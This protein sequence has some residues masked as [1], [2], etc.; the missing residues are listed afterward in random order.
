MGLWNSYRLRLERKK[1]RVRSL[2]KRRELSVVQ[3]RTNQIRPNDILCF[4]TIRD[5][6]VR[7]PFFLDYYRK[8]GVNHFFFVD[9][10]SQDGGREFLETQ[11]DVSVWTTKASYKRS[12]FGVDW[13][14]GLKH[15]Y[16]HNHW[17]LSVD[18]DEFFVYP[19][20]DE[21]PLSAL[22]DWL[23]ASS[24]R[25][26]GTMLLDMYPKTAIHDAVYE[27]GTDP[28][29]ISNYFDSGNYG[30]QKNPKYGNL[31]IQGGPRQRVFFAENPAFAPA[32]NKIPLV[33]WSR[34]TV[35]VSS[36]HSLLPRGLNLVYDEWGGQKACG[37]LLHQKFLNLFVQKA[38][39]ELARKQHY[40]ASR[41]YKSY[42]H[43]LETHK[44]LWTE[45]STKYEGW[46]QLERLGL[47]SAGNW[48]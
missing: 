3:K 15:A 14:N 6:H 27:K 2:R 16:A 40:A 45:L 29:D 44:N 39:E 13:L 32:L 48:A 30:V 35:F 7:L 12:R 21:R 1:H 4:S 11:P 28:L 9:N 41:E 38:E 37:V 42:A 8:L 20:C 17:I 5:E 19:F 24:I 33:K 22:T 18:V 23:D 25:S 31:W 43:N 26:F 36:T 10:D 47:L 34:G 46:R